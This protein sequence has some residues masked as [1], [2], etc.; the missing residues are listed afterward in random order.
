[1][2]NCNGME[3]PQFAGFANSDAA[4]VA[5]PMLSCKIHFDVLFK[6]LFKSS[7][8]VRGNL[9]TFSK[10]YLASVASIRAFC[11][12]CELCSIIRFEGVIKFNKVDS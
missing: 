1:M 9:V 5:L 7:G 12:P 4:P 10:T 11:M 3:D 6:A 8:G 2:N